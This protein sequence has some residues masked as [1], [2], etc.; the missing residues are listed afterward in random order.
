MKMREVRIKMIVDREMCMRV[1]EED[2]KLARQTQPFYCLRC[3]YEGFQVGR[4]RFEGD[5]AP[6]CMEHTTE[7]GSVEPFPMTPSR[8]FGGSTAIA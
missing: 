8:G 5:P 6:M 2:R 7:D 4:L 1:P 3:K